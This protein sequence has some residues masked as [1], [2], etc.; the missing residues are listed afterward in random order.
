MAG[1][2]PLAGVA[3]AE[4]S[5]EGAVSELEVAV[6]TAVGDMWTLAWG[7]KSSLWERNAPPRWNPWHFCPWM[8]PLYLQVL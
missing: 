2:G 7:I 3:R 6:P 4:L 5:R 1:R 8:F